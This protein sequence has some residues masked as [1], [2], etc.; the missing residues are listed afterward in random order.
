MSIQ[1]PRR[2]VTR[3]FIPL[4]DVLIL[5]FCIFLLMPIVEEGAEGPGGA[6]VT[7]AEADV[8]RRQIDQLRKQVTELE[9][10]RESPRTRDLEKEN[11]ELRQQASRAVG[12]RLVIRSFEID[13]KSGALTYQNPE[14]VEVR[15]QSDAKLL[16]DRDLKDLARRDEESKTGVKHQLYYLIITPRDLNNPFPKLD[17]RA[18]VVDWFRNQRVSVGWDFPRRGPGGGRLQ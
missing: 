7:A 12:E 18:R 1:M 14:R 9:A 5:M 11:E 13:P 10:T 2:S 6:K 16:M 4:I 3:F 8:L 15:D 17:Q